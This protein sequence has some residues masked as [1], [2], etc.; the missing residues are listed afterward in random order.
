MVFSYIITLCVFSRNATHI[1]YGDGVE[2]VLMTESLYNHLS[3]E[4]RKDDAAKYLKYLEKRNF[5][6]HKVDEFRKAEKIGD[7]DAA[8]V[9]GY[10]KSELNGNWY[11]YH[12]WMY[13]V[14]CVPARFIL[15][16]LQADIR[17]TGLMTNL[18]FIF[19]GMWLILRMKKFKNGERIILALFL[20]FSPALWYIDW[21]HT[22]VFSGVL[23]FL[24]VIYY[25]INRKYWS[26][27]FISLAATQN[28]TLFVL[29]LIVFIDLLYQNKLRLKNLTLLFLCSFWIILPSVFYKLNYGVTSIIS[30]SGVLSW[31]VVS[32]QRLWGFFFD[33]NQGVILGIPLLLLLLIGFIFYDIIKKNWFKPYIF[34]IGILIMSLFFMQMTVWNDG[35]AVIKRYAVWCISI[36]MVVFFLRLLK[37]KQVWVYIIGTLVI[38]S[39]IAAIFSQ[40]D[41]NKAY[42]HASHFNQISRF[43]MNNYPSLYNPE[44]IIFEFRLNQLELSS[45]DSVLV[46]TDDYKQIKK[47]LVKKGSIWQLERRGI[48][49]EKLQALEKE[50]NYQNGFSYINLPE[51]KQLGYD[52]EQDTLI[53]FIEKSKKAKIIDASFQRL[54]SD[55]SWLI[56]ATEETNRRGITID[57][58]ITEVANYFYTIEEEKFKSM[59]KFKTDNN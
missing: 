48:Q 54:K 49:K 58:Y 21:I 15:G 41:Y 3:P 2:Y 9:P 11:S 27:F 53:G 7:V 12:F 13:S 18:F 23:T 19:W 1:P 29:A 14:F 36:M 25:F 37:L 46:Y 5:K 59:K 42:W 34:L 40:Q 20:A 39:Q 31:D 38:L 26:L 57:E 45:T 17:L 52:Q 51:L 35:H 44:P 24:G 33:L 30:D 16:H 8:W 47:M 55:Q 28:P 6:I 50:L 4:L 10:Y 56:L 43:V 22:E 32:M